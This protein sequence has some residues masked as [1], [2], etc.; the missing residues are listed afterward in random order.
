MIRAVASKLRNFGRDTR[1]AVVIDYIPVFIALTILVLLIVEIGIAH[2]LLLRSQKSAQ[3][4]AR[5]A[6]TLPAAVPG[7]PTINQPSST[8]TGAN[9][10]C[11]SA[12]GP[13]NCIDPTPTGASGWECTGDACDA[14][15]MEVIVQEMQRTSPSITA[16][17]VTIK[18]IYR[19]LGYAGGPFVPEVNVSIGK[20][21]YDFA[22]LSLGDGER[23]ENGVYSRP[24]YVEL[25]DDG[26]K[27]YS[28]VSASAFGESMN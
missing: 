6:V 11:Y 27:V 1:G 18:Y 14:S 16:E 4:G 13:D 25:V 9:V 21:E 8:N 17:D 20:F 2:F 23:E 22:L 19:R 5:I 28:D 3:L 12:I 24:D 7:V 15:V 26:A 10:P